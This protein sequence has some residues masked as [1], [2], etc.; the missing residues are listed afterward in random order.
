VPASR[1][2]ISLP[3]NLSQ[4]VTGPVSIHTIIHHFLVKVLGCAARIVLHRGGSYGHQYPE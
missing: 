3:R 4:G 1:F 2:L